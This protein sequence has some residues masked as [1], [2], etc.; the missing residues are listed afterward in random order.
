MFHPRLV[1]FT[2]PY[3]GLCV[4]VKEMVTSIQVLPTSKLLTFKTSL[5]FRSNPFIYREINIHAP[6]NEVWNTR[7]GMKIPVLHL[8]RQLQCRDGKMSGRQRLL[9]IEKGF[10]NDAAWTEA[11]NDS[12]N[13]SWSREELCVMDFDKKEMKFKSPHDLAG[14]I[15]RN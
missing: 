7:Y 12:E 13:A 1:L 11:W 10:W 6:G 15:W 5:Q 9:D 3:C 4:P 8:Y 2:H 14:W